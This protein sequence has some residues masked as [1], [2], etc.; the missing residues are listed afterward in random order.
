MYKRGWVDRD[1]LVTVEVFRQMKEKIL[2]WKQILEK[3]WWQN[4]VKFVEILKRCWLVGHKWG[5]IREKS[6]DHII[7]RDMIWGDIIISGVKSKLK[8]KLVRSTD[9]QQQQFIS[10]NVN[11]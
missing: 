6:R 2:K 8:E 7:I 11:N 5:T 1:R 9:Q 4:N 10:T 3:N